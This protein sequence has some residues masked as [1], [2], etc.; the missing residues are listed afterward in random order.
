M[1][2]VLLRALEC[3]DTKGETR[4]EPYLCV[5]VN[6]LFSEMLGPFHMRRGDTHQF[7]LNSFE[8]DQIGIVLGESDS[9]RGTFDEHYGGVEI[10]SDSE[11]SARHLEDLV[12]LVDDLTS[13]ATRRDFRRSEGRH[14]ISGTSGHGGMRS[15]SSGD[16]R[17]GN[18]RIIDLPPTGRTRYKLYIWTRRNDEEWPACE[19]S[20]ELLSLH[21]H[22]AQQYADRVYIK[23]DGDTVWGPER[24]RT[25]DTWTIDPVVAVDIFDVSSVQLWEQDDRRDDFFGVL[26][27]EIDDEF[28][29]DEELS[30]P[31][32]AR[33]AAG[34]ARYTLRYR[35]RRL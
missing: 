8:G 24:F 32:T 25:G 28:R 35:V 19:Y 12:H 21:C 2:F 26:R 6:E 11:T 5:Y 30:C 22:D 18:M 17:R 33:H 9:R 20:L 29:F 15:T 14:E 34:S 13:S 23:V 7:D 3:I 27:L 10:V 16:T 1:A 31:F 4:E